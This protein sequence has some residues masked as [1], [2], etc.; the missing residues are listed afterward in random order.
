MGEWVRLRCR[1]IST[2]KYGGV[3]GG[4]KDASPLK[5]AT[6]RD[7]LGRIKFEQKIILLFG[8]PTWTFL[9]GVCLG[10]LG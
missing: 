3:N 8:W 10:D 2:T 9:K 6:L 1:K 5:R 7:V 4:N